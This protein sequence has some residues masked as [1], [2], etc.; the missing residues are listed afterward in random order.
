MSISGSLLINSN[1]IVNIGKDSYSFARVR[2]ISHAL[3]V[4]SVREGGDNTHVHTLLKQP[5]SEQKIIFERG[6]LANSDGR[7]DTELTTGVPVY[8]VTI[9]VLQ[10]GEVK[11]SYAFDRG[12]ITRW[13]LSGLD[14]LEGR[15][16]YRT[17][18]ITHSGLREV[19]RL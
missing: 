1:F 17:I 10:R 6:L 12:L 2:N 16:I 14:A 3:E 13:E 18:E 5:S 11:K 9:L 7:A 8:D 19:T 4:E 15:P